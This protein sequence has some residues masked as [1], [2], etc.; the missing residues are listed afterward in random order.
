MATINVGD[1]VRITDRS[2]NYSHWRDMFVIMGFRSPDIRDN[3]Y[4][5]G[6]TL[7]VFSKTNHPNR[8]G[9]TL[10]GLEPVDFGTQILMECEG[11][12]YVLPEDWYIK[13]TEENKEIL[14][15][16]RHSGPLNE[17]H[18]YV[19]SR[20]EPDG[21]HRGWWVLSTDRLPSHCQIEISTEQF[22]QYVLNPTFTNMPE[23][24]T[25]QQQ[26]D[27]ALA[28]MNLQPGDTVKVTLRFSDYYMGWNNVW[29]EGVMDNCIGHEY[30][31]ERIADNRSGVR[32]V[33]TPY[34]FPIYSLELVRR[35]NDPSPTPEPT[36][37]LENE[38]QDEVLVTTEKVIC[39]TDKW[40]Y[41]NLGSVYEVT[42]RDEYYTYV[43][44]EVGGESR[45]AH[46]YFEE[47]VHEDLKAKRDQF[48]SLFGDHSEHMF[49]NS[50]DEVKKLL[51]ELYPKLYKYND[52]IKLTRSDNNLS[53]TPFKAIDNSCFPIT[54]MNEDITSNE[55]LHGY[56]RYDHN[57]TEMNTYV[58]RGYT[59]IRFRQRH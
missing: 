47:W 29:N 58:Y 3:P 46:H 38:A 56:L 39:L 2:Q 17:V 15:Q 4:D 27:A 31:V 18:G 49:K 40:N 59:Y 53:Y 54:L 44:D 30:Q 12:E 5:N 50:G 6:T 55:A 1:L 23:Q 28:S 35:V 57:D 37:N 14:G 21:T 34:S 8:E 26:Y 41:V 22:F 48:R 7:R 11:I 43:K 24:L 32:L 42:K 20:L 9:V 13:V 52:W 45:Y 51:A 33:G 10:Y 19:C 25:P 36:S 16:W